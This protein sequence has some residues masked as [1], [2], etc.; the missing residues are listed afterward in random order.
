MKKRDRSSESRNFKNNRR[1][2]N[3]RSGSA[4]PRRNMRDDKSN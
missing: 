2:S 3:D 4:S 1:G